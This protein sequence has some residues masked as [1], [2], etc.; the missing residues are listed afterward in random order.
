MGPLSIPSSRQGR[1]RP[2][3]APQRPLGAPNTNFEHT[4]IAHKLPSKRGSAPHSDDD[5]SCPSAIT[6]GAADPPQHRPCWRKHDVIIFS[7]SHRGA[8]D[9]IVQLAQSAGP[10][11]PRPE[12][13]FRPC[14][15]SRRRKFHLP[16][17]RALLLPAAT[18]LLQA[19]VSAFVLGTEDPQQMSWISRL[20]VRW[21]EKW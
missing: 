11:V 13:V 7:P 6:V 16:A 19:T 17:S 4:A 12:C 20:A 8:Q 2:E 10:S 9:L 1:S 3:S 5:A 14:R 18:W 21:L 15:S